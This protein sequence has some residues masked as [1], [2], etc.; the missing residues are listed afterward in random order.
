MK[1][2]QASKIT[3]LT[4]KAIR[5]YEFEGFIIPEY[6]IYGN[7]E[8]TSEH[9]DKLF[10]IKLLR[11][12]DIPIE[13]IK[14]IL[15]NPNKQKSL[16]EYCNRINSQN[17]KYKIIR[18]IITSLD[19]LEYHHYYNVIRFM[20][21]EY[22][23]REENNMDFF[24]KQLLYLIPG[25]LGKIIFMYY[26]PFLEEPI[27]SEEKKKA[28]KDIIKFFDDYTEEIKLSKEI[29]DGLKDIK[30][31]D[32]INFLNQHSTISRNKRPVEGN[33]NIFKNYK[34][35]YKSAEELRGEFISN[36]Q[37]YEFLEALK[38]LSDSYRKYI[39]KIQR[40]VDE[41]EKVYIENKILI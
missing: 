26:G 3:N 1:I 5:Y 35:Y 11:N 21:K 32:L 25:P 22:F 37:Y 41:N 36:E 30:E 24:K 39:D 4:K 31:Q 20:N 27:N 10:E 9:I 7:R 15:T 18:K 19:S 12:L 6:D 40:S 38:I 8:F 29:R 28:W 33:L 17:I 14:K 2:E 13:Y 34:N 16:E 23:L